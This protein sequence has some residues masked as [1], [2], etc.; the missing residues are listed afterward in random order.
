MWIVIRLVLAAIGFAIRQFARNRQPSASGT[1]GDTPYFVNLNKHKGTIRGFSIGMDR[2]T[3][4][5]IRFH[6]ESRADRLFKAIGIANETQTGDPEFDR[7]V[8]VTCDHPHVATVLTE[9]AALRHAI[10][11]MFDDGYHRILFDGTVVWADCKSNQ[12]P[13]DRDVEL[14]K[15]VWLASTR[16]SDAPAGRT[17][18]RFLWKALVVEGVIWSLAGYAIGGGLEA[19]F[20]RADVHV[21]PSQLWTTA[22][23]VALAAFAALLMVIVVWLRGS[24][25]G[26]RVIIESALVLL[27]AM[28][29]TSV[30]VVADTNRALDRSAPTIV[31]HQFERCETRRHRRRRGGV[32]YS[33]HLHLIP[34]AD[35]AGPALPSEIEIAQSLCRAAV[36]PGPVKIGIGRGRWGIP[37]YRSITIGATT[38]NSGM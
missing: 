8:Y 16:L 32:S 24:S 30:Q 12:G 2:P 33:Y 18:D 14:L 5:W 22:M 10:L 31:E 9:T 7:R 3:P 20:S 13:A 28:P 35:T 1:L 36:T 37:W 6:A 21:F 19:V 11:A 26:H 38:W 29:L 27:V 4:T 23:A 17:A 15:A 34:G 25:R